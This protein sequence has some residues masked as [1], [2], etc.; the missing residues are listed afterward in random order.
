MCAW[1]ARDSAAVKALE[2]FKT[3]ISGFFFLPFRKICQL[4]V[5]L[6]F[7]VY[8]HG[9]ELWAPF[10]PPSEVHS[11][12][13]RWLL[14]LPKIRT[15]R[16]L[17]WFPIQNPD[18]IALSRALRVILLAEKSGGLLLEVVLHF[19]TNYTNAKGEETWWGNL[20][21][22]VRKIW[23][24][25]KIE[26]EGSGEKLKIMGVPECTSESTPKDIAV[27]F[28][29]DAAAVSFAQRRRD[30]LTTVPTIYQQ[31]YIVFCLFRMCSEHNTL[32]GSSIFPE[33]P[34]AA[35]YLVS[36]FVSVLSGTGGFARTHAHYELRDRLKAR[37]PEC[38]KR[39]CLLCAKEMSPFSVDLSP[40]LD[41]EW[42]MIFDCC[43]TRKA[44]NNYSNAVERGFSSLLLPWE[45]SPE[46]LVVHILRAREFPDLLRLLMKCVVDSYSLRQTALKR[47]SNA[48]I[49]AEFCLA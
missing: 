26:L 9:A 41:S 12:A 37:F 45:S 8:L 21:F 46:S 48:K 14:G 18:N 15:I 17:G 36:G 6:V 42:H 38:L 1:E 3:C 44:R 28:V 25:F 40:P 35:H 10:A 27:R 11:R 20:L 33:L 31:D 23:P 13:C 19:I 49:R 43:A 4:M 7:C 16:M 30:V 2:Y 29:A 24:H 34:I 47:L 39:A 22:R 32:D 5:S